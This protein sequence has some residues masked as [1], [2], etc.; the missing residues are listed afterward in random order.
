[1]CLQHS[2]FA[3][4]K[5]FHNFSFLFGP[6]TFARDPVQMPAVFCV[7]F[8]DFLQLLGF[9][10]IIWGMCVYNGITLNVCVRYIRGLVNRYRRLDEEVVENK[11]ADVPDDEQP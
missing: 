1:M 3:Q 5:P 7:T 9:V 11:T 4:Y 10:S 6:C 8:D 2:L